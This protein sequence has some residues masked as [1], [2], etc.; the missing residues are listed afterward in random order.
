MIP[1]ALGLFLGAAI[2][3]AAFLLLWLREGDRAEVAAAN[4]LQSRNRKGARP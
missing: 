3:T 4:E 2:A 1:F